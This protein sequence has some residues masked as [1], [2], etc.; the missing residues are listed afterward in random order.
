M[1]PRRPIG[2]SAEQ[3]SPQPPT[4]APSQQHADDLALVEYL[5]QSGFQG[6]EFDFFADQLIDH[7]LHVLHA[8]TISRK[9]F[10]KCAH[11]GIKLGDPPSDWTE[12][13]RCDLVQDTIFRAFKRFKEKALQARQWIPDGGASLKTY[14]I[15][16]CIY[17]FADEYRAW[18]DRQNARRLE[19]RNLAQQLGS[20]APTPTHQRVGAA[21]L[22]RTVAR[23]AL[24][25]L[26]ARDPRLAM[27]IALETDGYSH[28]EIAELL[29]DGTTPRAVEGALYRHRCR[30][31]KG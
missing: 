10:T 4:N 31:E 25:A 16:S 26:H 8:W 2:P 9:I 7:G 29:A 20:S 17:A 6:P 12:D 22:D 24:Q 27:I 5:E 23:K 11:K 18:L 30:I 3:P 21:V 15:G 1:L 19:L 14:F 28:K 13:D